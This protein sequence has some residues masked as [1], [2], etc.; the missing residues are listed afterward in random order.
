MLVV[1]YRTP[2]A[3]HGAEP[4]TAP[5]AAGQSRLILEALAEADWTRADEHR[6]LALFLRLGLTKK[7]GW[8]VPGELKLVA[9]AAR[10]WLRENAPTYRIRRYAP[11]ESPRK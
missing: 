5:I 3:V 6:P 11:A 7:D 10:K 4:R 9:P 1:R 8:V 2:R